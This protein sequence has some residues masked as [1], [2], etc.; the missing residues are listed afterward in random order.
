MVGVVSSRYRGYM[1]DMESNALLVDS[2]TWASLASEVS[3]VV[4]V[5]LN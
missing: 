2:L 5:L 3:E 4:G 1:A